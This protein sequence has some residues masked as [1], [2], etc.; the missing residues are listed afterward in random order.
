M[1]MLTVCSVYPN[2]RLRDTRSRDLEIPRNSTPSSL[3]T[4]VEAFNGTTLQV[5]AIIFF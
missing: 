5:G 2:S 3:A 1:L 4:F